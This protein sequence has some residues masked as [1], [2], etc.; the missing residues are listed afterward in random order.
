MAAPIPILMANILPP[1]ASRYERA[2]ASE[3]DRLLDLDVPLRT[4][5]DPWT[6]PENLLPYLAWTHSVDVWDV[7]WPLSRKREAVA[8]AIRLHQLKGTEQGLREAIALAGGTLKKVIAPPAKTFLSP[9]ITKEQ[10]DRFLSRYPQLRIYPRRNRGKAKGLFAT[11]RGTLRRFLEKGFPLPSE[12]FHRA[13][14]RAFIWDRGQETEITVLE[15]RWDTETLDIEERLEVKVPGTRRR[16]H[17]T[18][19]ADRR[20][21]A[22]RA[23]APGRMYTVHTRS[24]LVVPGEERLSR[25]VLHPSLQPINVVADSVFER[26]RRRT[27]TFG[28]CFLSSGDY[29]SVLQRSTARERTY[30]RTYLFDPSRPLEAH[31]ATTFLGVGRLGMPA[32]HAEITVSVRGKAHPFSVRRFVRGF[33]LRSPKKELD[34]VKD[35]IRTHK[36]LS[37]TIYIQT[38]TIRTVT[39]SVTIAAGDVVAG[40]VIEVI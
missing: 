22:L 23:T 30:K 2:L 12:A 27:A 26:G 33:V 17:C 3:V 25:R 4:I 20:M 9:N 36:R 39:S 29:R 32:H 6:C 31:G 16:N 15:R 40:Q 8:Q 11:G 37:D 24:S 14:P 28:S 19:L 38:R 18:F 5:W 34:L 35:A 13:L 21:F 1:N 7:D 10:R